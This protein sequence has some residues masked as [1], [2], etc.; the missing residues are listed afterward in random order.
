MAIRD[1]ERDGNIITVI[2]LSG[3]KS[4]SAITIVID[5][6]KFGGDGNCADREV[7]AI[8]IRAIS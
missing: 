3:I 5:G 6:A 7:I 1:S 8:N 2:I 4:P